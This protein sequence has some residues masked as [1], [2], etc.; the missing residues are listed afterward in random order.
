[1][2]KNEVDAIRAFNREY[3]LILGILNN[4][5]KDLDFSLT[6]GRVLFEIN[7]GENII[8]NQLA[9]KLQLDRSYLN[10]LINRLSHL[11]LIEKKNSESDHR[12][13]ILNLTGKG[14]SVLKEIN[15]QNEKMTEEI[16]SKFSQNELHDIIQTMHLITN[17][18]L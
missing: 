17:R 16:F 3:I 10:R 14:H 18:L 5:M 6:E 4:N 8:A 1:M 9:V 11:N 13:K 15:F 12:I 2:K 7:A